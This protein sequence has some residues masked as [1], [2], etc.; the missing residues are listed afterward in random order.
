VE[1]IREAILGALHAFSPV[2]ADDVALL[3]ARYHAP[4]RG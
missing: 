3:V 4:A 2:L 1:A